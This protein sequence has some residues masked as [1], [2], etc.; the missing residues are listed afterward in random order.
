MAI[1]PYSDPDFILGLYQ[2]PANEVLLAEYLLATGS[3]QLGLSPATQG[4]DNVLSI[5]EIVGPTPSGGNPNPCFFGMT[6]LMMGDGTEQ[7]IR[8][9]LPGQY[10]MGF[11]SRGNLIPSLISRLSIHGVEE[12]L[13][14]EFSDGREVFVDKIH[15]Y[16]Q[17]GENF[18]PIAEVTDVLHYAGGQW[19]EVAVRQLKQFRPGHPFLLY[20][21]TTEIGTYL[22]DGDG[23]HNAKP[24]D[25]LE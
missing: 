1:D 13:L 3:V 8:K 5:L 12:C 21:I 16:W 20:N 10:N 17:G 14:A 23:V 18:I 19:R 6:P 7:S 9:A 22:A 11:D 2:D 4:Q 24:R 25:P 15:P